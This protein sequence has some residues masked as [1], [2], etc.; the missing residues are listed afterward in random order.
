MGLLTVCISAQWRNSSNVKGERK[1]EKAK[2][3]EKKMDEESIAKM[4]DAGNLAPQ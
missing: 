1:Q 2:V 3:R 4:E